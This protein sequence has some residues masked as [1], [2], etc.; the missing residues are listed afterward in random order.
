MNN[1]VTIKTIQDNERITVSGRSLHEF[2]GVDTPYRLWFPRMTEYG[3]AEGTDY[4]PYNFVHPQNQQETIDHQLTVDMAKE[5]AMIQRTDKGKQARQYFLQLEKA[6]NSPEAIM[7]R[8]LQISR[9]TIKG[10]SGKIAMLQDRIEEMKPKELF[11]DSVTASSSSILVGDLAKILRQNG[12]DIGEIRLWAWMRKN[13]YAI[14][15]GCRSYNMPTQYS[16]D[17]GVMEVRE[18]TRISPDGVSKL[19]KTTLVTGKGQVYFVNKFLNRE[20]AND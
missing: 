1:L 17:R 4:T 6:W 20:A 7:A 5:I 8:A 18:G 15:E 13:G 12:I 16:L 14:K 3:F 19:T 11:A 2:L 9:K 10:L